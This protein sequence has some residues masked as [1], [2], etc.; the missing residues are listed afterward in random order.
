MGWMDGWMDTAIL[1]PSR[2]NLSHLHPDGAFFARHLQSVSP[3]ILIY[4][5]Y[6]FEGHRHHE[7]QDAPGRVH[8]T[9]DS[10]N[11]SQKVVR[12]SEDE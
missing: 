12:S 4:Y 10:C 8:W 9:N 2:R 11:P 3:Y 7:A 1:R 5:Y 6:P